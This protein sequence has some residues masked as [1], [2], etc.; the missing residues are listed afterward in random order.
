MAHN[1]YFLLLLTL[2]HFFLSSYSIEV[3]NIIDKSSIISCFI[4]VFSIVQSCKRRDFLSFR[5]L[6]L[7][8]TNMSKLEN[9][10]KGCFPE[11]R[12]QFKKW[13]RPLS[14]PI[15][16]EK[17]F[18]SEYIYSRIYL[19]DIFH[20]VNRYIYLD[21]DIVVNMD[22]SDLY[23]TPL[24]RSSHPLTTRYKKPYGKK[25]IVDRSAAGILRKNR[26]N[27]RQTSIMERVKSPPVAIGFVFDSNEKLNGYVTNGFNQSN[28]MFIKAMSHIER[29]K[30]FNGGVALVDAKMWRRNNMTSQAEGIIRQNRNGELYSR[31]GLGDQGLFFLLLQEGIAE[32]HPAYNMRRVPNKTTR[33][34]K[35]KLGE[36]RFVYSF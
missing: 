7:D 32:L 28:P 36:I 6:V 26:P 15:L 29:A 34:L 3:I 5:F 27:G 17:G 4:K 11:I 20:D 21:N 14:L 24:I 33:Y 25:L 10:Y 2:S 1:V 19:S 35:D 9:I 30:F 13:K 31:S 8:D 22:I 12:V 23:K 16:S 18:D